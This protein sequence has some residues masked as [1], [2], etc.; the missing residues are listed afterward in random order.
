MAQPLMH[1][2]FSSKDELWRAAVAKAFNE[3]LVHQEMI[4]E[5]R[6]LDP[7]S[8]LR[9]LVIRHISFLARH[10]SVAPLI[11]GES[12][13][14]SDRIAWL[15]DTYIAPLEN[16]LVELIRLGQKEGRIR[17]DLPIPHVVRFIVGGASALFTYAAPM[18]Q[19]Y[20]IDT[21]DDDAVD[22]YARVTTELLFSGMLVD[23]T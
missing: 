23:E 13:F 21:A 20:D 8:G 15:T 9:L 22:T 11:A 5:L 4:K 6:E 7:V 18:K 14:T 19:I 1:Y 16:H 12:Q 10:P 17:G 2:Y 3:M